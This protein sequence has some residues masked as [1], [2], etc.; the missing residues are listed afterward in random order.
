[1]LALS[2]IEEKLPFPSLCGTVC[3][4][5]CETA[6]TR[7]AVD[8]PVAIKRLKRFVSDKEMEML[9]SG[10]ISLPD[11]ITPSPDAKKVAVIGAGPSGLT[12]AADL[13]DRGYAVTLYE[14]SS[15]AGGVIRREFPEFELP[16]RVLDYEIELIRRKG[17]SFIFDCHVGRDI[18]I[19][20]LRDDY[21]A[22]FIGTGV[23][24]TH[25]H[26]IKGINLRGVQSYSEI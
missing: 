12:V 10:E 15:M 6:C 24:N 18:P 26:G 25:P 7:N 4:H 22:L 21:D 20:K 14:S 5:P 3:T 8:F 2:I 19:E 9:D 13:A 11:E 16:Q 23:Q 17:V 1:M